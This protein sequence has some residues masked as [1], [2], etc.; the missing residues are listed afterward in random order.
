MAKGRAKVMR[1]GISKCLQ[2]LIT[3]FKRS[4]PFSQFFVEGANLLLPPSALGDVIVGFQDRRGPPQVIS[5]Q[6][7][8]ARYYYLSSVSPGLLELA[9]PTPGTQQLRANIINRRRKSRLQTLVSAL[10][11]RFLRRPAIQLLRSPVPVIEDV[12]HISDDS[13]VVREI[14]PAGRRAPS[15]HFDFELVTTQ[16]TLSLD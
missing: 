8:S 12:A 2:F 7:P 10:P 15:R 9:V 1:Y 16:T 5:P 11:D 4:A 3:G 6:R 13:A 14:R